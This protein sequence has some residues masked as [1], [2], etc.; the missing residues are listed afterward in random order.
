MTIKIFTNRL[1]SDNSNCSISKLSSDFIIAITNLR[2]ELSYI[3]EGAQYV[4]FMID[5]KG[6]HIFS[7]GVLLTKL[8]A[9]LPQPTVNIINDIIQKN[10]NL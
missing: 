3:F 7:K 4:W 9:E 5:D 2:A 10:E 8:Y 6:L 1:L